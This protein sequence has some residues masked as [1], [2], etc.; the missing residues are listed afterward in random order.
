MAG[1]ATRTSFAGRT[2]RGAKTNYALR[3]NPDH[4]MAQ[5]A[6]GRMRED[7]L[8]EIGCRLAVGLDT[9]GV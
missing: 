9:C 3:F 1:S 5:I 6:R 4:P 7:A 2:S 8:A